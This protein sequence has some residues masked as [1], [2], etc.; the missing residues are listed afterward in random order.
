MTKVS[1]LVCIHFGYNRK[2]TTYY[3]SIPSIADGNEV[4]YR[5]M[6]FLEDIR[7][8]PKFEVKTRK[9]QRHSTAE[10]LQTVQEEVSKL[11]LCDVCGPL[12]KIHWEDY[13]GSVN[14]KE[15]GIDVMIA[16]DMIDLGVIEN[17]C[18]AC[19]L[20]SG[21]ADFISAM[22]LIKACKKEVF[23]ASLAKGYSYELRMKHKW[24]ILDKKFILNK[25]NK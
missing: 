22:D 2:R 3:N 24:F 19:I 15:K 9:L 6:K 16:V 12:V 10:K 7:K 14:V 11:G 4:Y 18:D 1:D 13:I 20:I 25:C 8:L 5:H 23:S 17:K 21:D